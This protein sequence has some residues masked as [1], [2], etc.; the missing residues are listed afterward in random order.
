[1]SFLYITSL[2]KKNNSIVTLPNPVHRIKKIQNQLSTCHFSRTPTRPL[3]SALGKNNVR[4][5]DLL[6]TFFHNNKR[7]LNHEN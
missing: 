5:S 2:N 3:N 7:R 6:E 4:H 1:M